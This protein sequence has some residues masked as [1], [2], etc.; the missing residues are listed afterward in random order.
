[1]EQPKD[2]LGQVLNIKD[3]VVVADSSS[4]FLV[5]LDRVSTGN[6]DNIIGTTSQGWTFIL[7]PDRL[8]KRA[9]KIPKDYVNSL[10]L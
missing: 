4:V 7:S 6:P 1:M 5:K 8:S 10:Y 9:I 3:F 2:K